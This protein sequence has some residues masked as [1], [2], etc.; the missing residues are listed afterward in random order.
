MNAKPCSMLVLLV[1][2]STPAFAARDPFWP[3]GYEPPKPEAAVQEEAKPVIK[4]PDPPAVKPITADDWAE[5]RKQLVV[6]GYA[7][8]KRP[9]TGETR[10]QVMINRATFC[11]GDALCVT[12]LDVRFVWQIESIVDRKLS[13]KQ[14]LA[15]RLETHRLPDQ[16]P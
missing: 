2:L 15:E 14:V 16:N 9:D 1:A 5:A 12:N 11:A 8:S 13:L 4:P 10:T 6:N 3:I 7:Q